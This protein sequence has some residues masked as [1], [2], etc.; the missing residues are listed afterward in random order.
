MSVRIRIFATVA[1]NNSTN[2][3]TWRRRPIGCLIFM[4]H[5]PQKSP[6]VS[7]SFVESD[8]QVTASYGSSPPCMHTLI[9]TLLRIFQ[10]K[11]M[12]SHTLALA[13]AARI[14]VCTYSCTRSRAHTHARARAHARTHARTLSQARAHPR[15]RSLSF[16]HMQ[17]KG[18]KKRQHRHT[19]T[20]R[21]RACA[22]ERQSRLVREKK[23]REQ[24]RE[25]CLA[26]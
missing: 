17:R 21:T 22:G 14:Y 11:F 24:G 23:T 25:S 18:R 16:T 1:G 6:V 7:G 9:H 4:G 15:A 5:F 2:S 8:L 26:I 19:E 20:E 10:F 3:C 12:C 13:T